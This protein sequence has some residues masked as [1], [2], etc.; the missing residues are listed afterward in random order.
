M[1]KVEKKF[2]IETLTQ[3]SLIL[4]LACRPLPS[5]AK[6]LFIKS[7]SSFLLFRK[8]NPQCGRTVGSLTIADDNCEHFWRIFLPFRTT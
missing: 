5:F 2:D 6:K 7:K 3:E 1:K 8:K 4:S